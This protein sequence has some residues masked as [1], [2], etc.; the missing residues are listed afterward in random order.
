MNA[1]SLRRA[2]ERKERKLA[3]KAQPPSAAVV[4]AAIPTQISAAKLAANQAN[5][6]L[7]SGPRSIEGKAKV[8]LNAV[9][10]G[11][12][13]RTVL[14]PGDDADE[15]RA[16]IDSFTAR[17]SPVGDA[18]CSLVQSLVAIEWRLHRIQGIEMA[19]YAKGRLEFAGEFDDQG[20]IDLETYLRYEKQLKNLH[21]QESRLR[22]NREK[23]TAELRRLQQERLEKE[24]ENDSQAAEP[25]SVPV[26]V[27]SVG[28]EFS[29]A[30]HD[31]PAALQ[32]ASAIP[33]TL[34]AVADR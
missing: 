13:G 22:R 1:R 23:D 9:K 17:W 3:R 24:Q 30:L 28:F 7:S 25:P 18:E 4:A 16:H 34:T 10:T 11:L 26:L 19:I 2:Q 5:A 8:S 14:L 27:P 20:M 12:T 31:R 15:Y 29:N 32:P 33:E 6:L 21:L